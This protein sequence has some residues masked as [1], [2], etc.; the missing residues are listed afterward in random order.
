MNDDEEPD[1]EALREEG[2]AEE[3]RAEFWE[4]VAACNRKLSKAKPLEVK[5]LQGGT[6]LVVTMFEEHDDPLATG[7]IE[8]TILE[9]ASGK[10]LVKDRRNFPEPAE[11]TLLGCEHF[12]TPPYKRVFWEGI[13]RMFYWLN[14]EVGGKK[15]D[16]E[17][18]PQTIRGIEVRL[19]SG[20]SFDLWND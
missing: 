6:R 18:I 11:G 4:R 1:W 8:F 3:R 15:F 12:T 10:V 14:Y 2:Q 5:T 16:R 17:N 13:L 20:T 7:P 9:P 19:P